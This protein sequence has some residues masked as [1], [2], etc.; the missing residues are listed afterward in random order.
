MFQIFQPAVGEFWGQA[1]DSAIPYSSVKRPLKNRRVE[2]PT[3]FFA[4]LQRESRRD[5]GESFVAQRNQRIDLRRAACSG[6][7]CQRRD[8]KQKER[9]HCEDQ[10]TQ[11]TQVYEYRNEKT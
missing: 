6:Q 11:S 2:G 9:G 3:P 5:H 10:G 1:Y 8:D 4:F 7:D